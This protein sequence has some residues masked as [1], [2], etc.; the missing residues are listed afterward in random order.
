VTSIL[1]DAGSTPARAV[2]FRTP[3]G[4]IEQFLLSRN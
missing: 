4:K 3:S 2:M 1:F